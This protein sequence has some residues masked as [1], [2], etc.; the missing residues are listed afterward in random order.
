MDRPGLHAPDSASPLVPVATPASFGHPDQ[1]ALYAAGPT[2][3]TPNRPDPPPRVG[4]F[5]N[6]E[7]PTTALAHFDWLFGTVTST[8]SVEMFPLLSVQVTLIV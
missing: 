7:I 8:A 3:T 5:A 2:T 4:R 6:L 1:T